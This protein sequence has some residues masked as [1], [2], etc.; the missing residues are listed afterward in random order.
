MSKKQ[1]LWKKKSDNKPKNVITSI[2]TTVEVDEIITQKA[3]Q[4]GSKNKTDFIVNSCLQNTILV[5]PEGKEI[6]AAVQEART[7]I[8]DFCQTDK[9]K[10]A[11]LMFSKVINRLYCVIS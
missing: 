1:P 10:D 7:L 6:L 11:D 8:R 5:I 2:R 3:K 9:T 4:S